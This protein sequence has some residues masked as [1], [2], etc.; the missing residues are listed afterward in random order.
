MSTPKILAAAAL[1]AAALALAA[2]PAG[3]AKHDWKRYVLAPSS[4]DVAPTEV[5]SAA[6]GG[7]E[8]LRPDGALRRDG[9][10]LVL[11]KTFADSDPR[12]V[13][14]LG[15]EVGGYLEVD[16]A[17]R[18]REHAVRVQRVARLH[19]R[20]RRHVRHDEL[21]RQRRP[22]RCRSA[23]A[24]SSPRTSTRP[25]PRARGATRSCAAACAT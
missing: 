11:R 16:F 12:V 18:G 5:V 2:A 10:S 20:P 9:R 17:A 3:A 19:A 15:R 25:P 7:G 6:P 22:A 24:A 23:S 14:D 8:I 4:R 1:A 21:H 13:L